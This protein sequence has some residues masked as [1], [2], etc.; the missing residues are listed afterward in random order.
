MRSV[1]ISTYACLTTGLAAYRFSSQNQQ[2]PNN[3]NLSL[4]KFARQIAHG[5]HAPTHPLSDTPVFSYA[6]NGEIKEVGDL[7]NMSPEV[8]LHIQKGF[9]IACDPNM[10]QKSKLSNGGYKIVGAVIAGSRDPRIC[11]ILRRLSID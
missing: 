6:P 9:F 7:T 2:N 5:H 11:E 4:E 1:I 3:E 10:I 8:K